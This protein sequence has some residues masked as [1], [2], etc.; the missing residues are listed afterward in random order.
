MVDT[1]VGL[2]AGMFKAGTLVDAVAGLE[3][4]VFGTGTLVDVGIYVA[5]AWLET[6]SI[7]PR[8]LPKGKK[9]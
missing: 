3:A 6:C 2:E 7:E 8:S 5:P 9:Y 4:G 1:V